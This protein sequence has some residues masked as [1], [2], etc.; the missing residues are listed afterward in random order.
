MRLF[1]RKTSIQSLGS[2]YKLDNNEFYPQTL[3]LQRGNCR[4]GD[5]GERLVIH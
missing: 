5:A 2:F 3:Q 1:G 4:I